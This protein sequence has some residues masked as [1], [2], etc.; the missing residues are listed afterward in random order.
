MAGEDLRAHDPWLPLQ[1]PKKA[2]DVALS[3]HAAMGPVEDLKR[4]VNLLPV[5]PKQILLS[6]V[7][8]RGACTP[9]ETVASPLVRQL[10]CPDPTESVYVCVL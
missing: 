9:P 10:L 7:S 4:P 8:L 2:A 5:T 3:S 6:A 1:G